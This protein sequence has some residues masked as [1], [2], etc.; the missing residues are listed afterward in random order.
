[1]K[2]NNLTTAI[3]AGITGVAGIASVSNAVNLNP[4]GIGQVLIYP[5]YTVRNDLRTL[6]S[7]VNTSDKVKAIKV[8]FLE[9]KNS[10]EVLD[11]NLYMSPY[12]VWTASLKNPSATEEE[13][14]HFS[15]DDNSCIV[16]NYLSEIGQDFLNFAYTGGSSDEFNDSGFSAGRRTE[17]HFEMIEMGDLTDSA[18]ITA[19]THGAD[20]EPSDC[21]VLEANWNTGGKWT[22]DANDGVVATDVGG[23]V[24]GSTTIVDVNDGLA[25]TYNADA[26]QSFTDTA[27]HSNPGNLTPNLTNGSID[28][29]TG[30]TRSYVF[31]NGVSVATDWTQNSVQAVSAV[32]THEHIFGEYAI[33]LGIQAATQWV[34]TFPT[35]AFYVD[36]NAS[37]FA[38]V[39]Y[40]PF[41]AT[42]SNTLAGG[43]CEQ[44]TPV[45]LYDREEQVRQG[46]PGVV[47]PSPPPPP[48]TIVVSSLCKE[49]NV[50]EFT[51][52]DNDDNVVA[53]GDILGSQNLSTVNTIFDAGWLNLQF[54][55]STNLGK[56]PGGRNQ[57]YTGL[58]VTGFA[59]QKYGNDNVGSGLRAK[60]GAIFKHRGTKS[61]VSI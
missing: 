13:N 59:V 41:T 9:G 24:F 39:P 60:F 36:G 7:V 17:G 43:Y 50:L 61:I 15:T 27:L 30:A 47:L 38:T 56:A 35:K 26:I 45:G 25:F 37:P 32:Y 1:M 34:M 31:N 5:Y 57:E 16:P 44:F 53:T 23:G 18:D 29:I 42:Y 19:A 49:T 2:R 54:D 21:S 3:L 51:Q 8:R 46:A 33:D 55:Q 48:G 52:V 58:P 10:R 40:E 11:F 6:I 28:P 4:D 14:V 22:V 20:G 12:D